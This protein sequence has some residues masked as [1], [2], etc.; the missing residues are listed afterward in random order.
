VALQ[1]RG[2]AADKAA[3]ETDELDEIMTSGERLPVGL[4]QSELVSE[5]AGVWVDG[6]GQPILDE[7]EE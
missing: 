7:E 4:F 5:R 3:A 2:S 6:A 1:P